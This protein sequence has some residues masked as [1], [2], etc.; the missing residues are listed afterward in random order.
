[1]KARLY[2]VKSA[3]ST[4]DFINDIKA[5]MMGDSVDNCAIVFS[6]F[7]NTI[8]ACYYIDGE[9]SYKG[10]KQY[11]SDETDEKLDELEAKMSEDFISRDDEIKE[12]LET[13][14]DEAKE[15]ITALNE[16]ISTLK[17]QVKTLNSRISQLETALNAKL[18]KDEL[19]ELELSELELSE[20][21]LEELKNS[22]RGE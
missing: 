1:M 2:L 8:T 18:N 22:I 12:L 4:E 20:L 17:E 6:S 3:L 9:F 19:K 13:N 7:D 11:S 15:Q 14:A 5:E 21:D 16:Q 10:Y